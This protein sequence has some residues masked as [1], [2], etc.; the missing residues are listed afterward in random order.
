MS[1]EWSS[2]FSYGYLRRILQALRSNFELH[3]LSEGLDLPRA[4][5]RPGV[6]LRHD[7]DVSLKRAL[8]VAE[9]ERECGVRAT[10]MV[11]VNSALYSLEDQASREILQRLVGMGHEVTLHFN[12]DE[13]ERNSACQ[14][15]ALETKIYAARRYLEQVAGRPVRSISFHRPLVQFLHGPRLIAGMVNAYAGE[16]MGWYLSDSKGRWREGE[17]LAKL[18]R[19]EEDLLQLLIHPIWWGSEHM[20]PEERLQ[21]FFETETEGQARHTIEAFDANL[22]KAI[23]SVRRMGNLAREEAWRPQ[24]SPL[25]FRGS[26][27]P[28]GPDISGG[29]V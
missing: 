15:G 9:I 28:D 22:A 17:P 6:I 7:I 18:L 5:G 13:E 19:P 2:D 4:G 29:R 14:I 25:H 20:S 10:Y 23:P 27:R 21:E 1:Q 16:L 11:M 3:L 26:L 24:G 12:V 8:R